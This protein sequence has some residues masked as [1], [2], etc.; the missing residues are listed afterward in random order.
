MR[1][2]EAYGLSDIFI[3]GIRFR[4]HVI[5]DPRDPDGIYAWNGGSSFRLSPPRK[6]EFAAAMQDFCREHYRFIARHPIYPFDLFVSVIAEHVSLEQGVCPALA[7]KACS[8]YERRPSV[9]KT[10]PLD[11]TVPEAFQG[12][13]LD[14]FRRYIT[15]TEDGECDFE[16]SAPL[17]F[18]GTRIVVAEDRDAWLRTT[19]KCDVA[20]QLID[21]H[22]MNTMEMTPEKLWHVSESGFPLVTDFSPAVEYLAKEDAGAG[23]IFYRNQLQMINSELA[24]SGET[25]SAESLRQLTSFRDHYT[26]ILEHDLQGP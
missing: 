23:N 15:S 8:I 7:D 20:E 9:C 19:A 26:E 14:F 22:L 11:G 3:P 21:S 25:A 5:A 13:A 1:L 12:E 17:M 10:V 4:T 16:A 2:A 6:K 24:V 18:E